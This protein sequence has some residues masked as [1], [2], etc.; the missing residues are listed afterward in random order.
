RAAADRDVTLIGDNDLTSLAMILVGGFRSVQ[1]LEADRSVVEFLV[2]AVAKLG[3]ELDIGLD[4]GRVRIREFDARKPLP[5][6]LTDSADVVMCDP[7][8]RLYRSFFARANEL[9]RADGVFYTFVNPSHSPETGQF[10]FQRDIIAAGWVLTDS[11]PVINESPVRAGAVLPE[12]RALYPVPTDPDDAISFT[13]SLLRFVRG[14][15]REA[16]EEIRRT[17][18]D[19]EGK[20]NT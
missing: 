1:V 17:I 2:K 14:P 6:D 3:T 11:I 18:H 7:S 20:T 12:Q 9:L 8:R 5:G 4:I 10:I 13:E 16:E 19:R 15:G